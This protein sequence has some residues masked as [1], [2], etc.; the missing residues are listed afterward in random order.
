MEYK[1]KFESG[2]IEVSDSEPEGEGDLDSLPSDD[3][4]Q[5]FD[6]CTVYSTCTPLLVLLQW[7]E[8]VPNHMQLLSEGL[9]MPA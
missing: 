1:A 2:E 9:T 7:M 5:L 3:D 8:C 4:G 6:V